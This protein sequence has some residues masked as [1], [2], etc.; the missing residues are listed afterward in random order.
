MEYIW[1]IR[2]QLGT[3]KVLIPATAVVV[4]NAR[5]EV[6]LHLRDDTLSWGL[7]GGLMD[8]G[9]TA[10]ESARREVWEETGLTIGVPWLYGV[11]SGPEFEVTYANGDETAPVILGFATRDYQG[12]LAR[13][14]ESLELGFFPLSAL[15]ENMNPS[16]RRFLDGYLEHVRLGSS[17]PVA[18]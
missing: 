15:P 7:P 8:I 11:F 3:Q 13:T 18:H 12:E 14:A 4:L 5:D 2:S 16:H 9:E 17:R 1:R 10:V 6:L